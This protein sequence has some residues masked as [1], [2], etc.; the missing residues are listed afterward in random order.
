MDRFTTATPPAPLVPEKGPDGKRDG[1]G[2]GCPKPNCCGSLQALPDPIPGEAFCKPKKNRK[3]IMTSCCS[4]C[5]CQ[6]GHID[7]VRQRLEAFAEEHEIDISQ[8]AI[9]RFRCEP[10]AESFEEVTASFKDQCLFAACLLEFQFHYE[11]HASS[12]F[13]KTSR[14]PQVFI[15]FVIFIFHIFCF[16]L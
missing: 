4:A 8:E 11:T 6:F 14:T 5:N 10:P 15:I 12:C 9:E 16:F 2:I 1:D 7:V 13:Q 3:P